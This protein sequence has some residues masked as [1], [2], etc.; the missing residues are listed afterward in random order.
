MSSSEIINIRKAALNSLGE[1]FKRDIVDPFFADARTLGIPDDVS[2]EMLNE[3]LFHTF[4]G[5]HGFKER[6]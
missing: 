5:L 4:K 1:W 6:K 3:I 2:N